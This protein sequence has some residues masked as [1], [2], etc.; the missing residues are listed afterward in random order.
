MEFIFYINQNQSNSFVTF[1]YYFQFN[2]QAL[3]NKICINEKLD[4]II[5]EKINLDH[6][7][8]QVVKSSSKG[9]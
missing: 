4:I 6:L 7:E 8:I 3:W 1:Y 9:Q 2:I 5:S